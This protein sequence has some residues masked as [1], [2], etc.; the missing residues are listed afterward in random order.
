MN[1]SRHFSCFVQS[2]MLL[3]RHNY[4]LDR[5]YAWSTQDYLLWLFYHGC[6][7]RHHVFRIRAPTVYCWE[8]HY[9]VSFCRL[10]LSSPADA[11]SSFGNGLNTSTV[12][13]WQSECSKS[14]RRGQLVMIEVGN[15]FHPSCRNGFDYVGR[16][17]YRWH[18]LQ[19]LARL[20][21]LFP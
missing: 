20:R 8:N 12:P 21:F 11:R 13:T 3:R 18:L 19:L 9:W 4:Y 1:F 5:E 14:H 15:P 17:H 10:H 7:C 6:W 16:P 2:R